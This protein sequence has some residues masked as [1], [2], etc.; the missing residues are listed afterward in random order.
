MDLSPTGKAIIGA[1]TLP[2]GHNI[3]YYLDTNHLTEHTQDIVPGLYEGGFK[4]WEC[5]NDMAHFMVDH[6]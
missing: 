5:T 1:L 4:L 3:R 2:Q 6:P